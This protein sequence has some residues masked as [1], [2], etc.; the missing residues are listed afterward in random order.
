MITRQYFPHGDATSN[1]VHNLAKELLNR[2]IDVSV[3]ALT[4][5]IEDVEVRNWEGVLIQN[6]Y[7]PCSIDREQIKSE[8]KKHF[9][10][11]VY[12]TGQRAYSAI[13]G[14]LANDGRKLTINPSFENTLKKHILE[15]QDR[16][17]V[18]LCIATLMPIEASAALMEAC[19]KDVIVSI[20]QLDTYWNNDWLPAKYQN[21][22]KQYEKH[23]IE[24]ADYIVTTPLIKQVDDVMFSE[25]SA[26]IIS[27]EFPL[28]ISDD[29]QYE[30][31]YSDHKI[32]CV[33]LGRLYKGVRPPELVVKTISKIDKIG[34]QFDFYGTGQ[35][36]I[37]MM[38]ENERNDEIIQL[39]G[40]VSSAEA[41]RIQN[42]ADFLVN[43]DNTTIMQVPSKI[44]DYVSTGKPIINFY[45]ND[46]SPTLQYLKRYPNCISINVYGD[47]DSE[48]KKL[49]V[50]IQSSRKVQIP[51]SEVKRLYEANTPEYVADLFISKYLDIKQQ[52]STS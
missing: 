31:Y 49:E 51:F 15:Y 37:S 39:H 21:Q 19:K 10:R 44:F 43:I 52:K 28:V 17:K 42:T 48:A 40:A 16:M 6:I 18:D 50:F 36:L 7:T 27:A 14:K 24:C 20:Y 47:L 32:H 9:L 33:Y 1:V 12:A 23:L 46:D 29:Q 34:A 8:W 35:H 41:K 25:S 4:S 30:E 3:M 38:P 26:K 11:T 2:D 45:F 5:R 13:R 22:R